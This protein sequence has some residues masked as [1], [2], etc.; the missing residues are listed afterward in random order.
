LLKNILSIVFTVI[1]SY[2][3]ISICV[4]SMIDSRKKILARRKAAAL[5]KIEVEMETQE[6]RDEDEKKKMG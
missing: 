2:A 5:G 4:T 3:L 1:I 6:M